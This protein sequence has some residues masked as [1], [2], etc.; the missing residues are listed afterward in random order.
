MIRWV[1]LP[2]MCEVPGICEGFDDL[3]KFDPPACM[4]PAIEQDEYAFIERSLQRYH[5]RDWRKANGNDA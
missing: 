3:S 2:H 1:K 4:K 5:D